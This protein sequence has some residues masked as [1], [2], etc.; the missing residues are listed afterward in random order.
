[1][2]NIK[3]ILMSLAMMILMT[4][5]VFAKSEQPI[6]WTDAIK[7]VP[8]FQMKDNTGQE[9][10]LYYDQGNGIAKNRW[11]QN[12]N[13]DWFYCGSDGYLLKST[14]LHD[15]GDGKYYYLG[16]DWVMLHD[17]TTPDGYT[18]GSDGAWVRDGQVVVETDTSVT[19]N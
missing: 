12:H 14:W 17:T 3:V 13:Y 7:D 6:P 9:G 5:N 18:V 2:K 16:D 15:S 10:W 4:S 8:F 11:V 1:M 19:T